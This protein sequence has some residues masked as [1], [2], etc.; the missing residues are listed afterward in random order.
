[1]E[2]S[3]VQ[4]AVW[5]CVTAIGGIAE[6]VNMKRVAAI[7]M[8]TVMGMVTYSTLMHR[9]DDPQFYAAKAGKDYHRKKCWLMVHVRDPIP[10]K[11]EVD[12]WNDGKEPCEFCITHKRQKSDQVA[13][14]TKSK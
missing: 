5:W 14:T 2:T 11:T 9:V 6:Y 3:I 12:A 10:Y 7:C 13:M 8:L 1:M 4:L